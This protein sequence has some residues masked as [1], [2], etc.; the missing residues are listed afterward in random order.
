MAVVLD[1]SDK[2]AVVAG[3]IRIGIF[4]IMPNKVQTEAQYKALFANSKV[5]VDLI[6]IRP[7]S[8]RSK[9]VDPSHL[10]A[11]YLSYQEAKCLG[12]DGMIITGAPIEHLP[13]EAVNYWEELKEVLD[14]ICQRSVPALFICWASQAALYHYYGIEKKPLME[15]M[16]G[17]FQHTL[18]KNDV[19]LEGEKG[20]LNA[21]H[22]RHTMN[23]VTDILEHEQLDI[24]LQSDEAGAFMIKDK[25]HPF[26]YISGHMEYDIEALDREYWRDVRKGLA[27]QLPKAYYVHN[28][29]T[30]GI[31]DTWR[32]SAARL[33]DRWLQ[34]Y[35]LTANGDLCREDGDNLLKRRPTAHAVV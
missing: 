6:W 29:P 34:N 14:D 21:P 32:E 8:H 22:S 9:N 5:K 27:I 16:F 30:K 13:F 11:H 28:D 19:L 35:L 33:A 3:A 20:Y 18:V 23:D 4:N 24:L 7:T 17:I 31:E 12:L 2:F 1:K 10:E 26:Y 25:L 15:K